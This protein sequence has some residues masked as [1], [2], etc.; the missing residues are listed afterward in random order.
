MP[1]A[2]FSLPMVRIALISFGIYLLSVYK[3]HND[4]NLAL[5]RMLDS[6]KPAIQIHS[7]K[8]G[9]TP[10]GVIYNYNHTHLTETGKLRLLTNI[11]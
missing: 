5:K 4:I 10:N 11:D 1:L 3:I 9:F 7:F 6:A 2:P 8:K